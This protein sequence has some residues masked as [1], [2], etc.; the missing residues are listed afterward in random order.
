MFYF[1]QLLLPIDRS[2]AASLMAKHVVHRQGSV[3]LQPVVQCA[4]MYGGRFIVELKKKVKSRVTKYL[5]AAW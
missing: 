4:C 1:L 3:G 5:A 2:T